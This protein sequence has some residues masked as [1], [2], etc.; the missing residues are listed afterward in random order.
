MVFNREDLKKY[1]KFLRSEQFVFPDYDQ[2]FIEIITNKKAQK[3]IEKMSFMFPKYITAYLNDLLFEFDAVLTDPIEKFE[4][5]TFQ[6]QNIVD[7]LNYLANENFGLDVMKPFIMQLRYFDSLRNLDY[8]DNDKNKI[9]NLCH[10]N[11]CANLILSKIDFSRKIEIWNKEE[12]EVDEDEK[13]KELF[14]FIGKLNLT[15]D[16][17]GKILQV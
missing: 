2:V 17:K 14:K 8:N 4:M 9:L 5:R 13:L 10:D 1:I 16:V 12:Q 11:L 15:L 3:A 6:E 7:Y